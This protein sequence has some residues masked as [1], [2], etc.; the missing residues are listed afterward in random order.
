MRTF[1]G[2]RLVFRKKLIDNSTKFFWF[3][4]FDREYREK[5][6][7]KK[8]KKSVIKKNA[9]LFLFEIDKFSFFCTTNVHKQR[10]I[11]STIRDF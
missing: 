1:K 2:R 3:V 6:K 4:A 11:R 7:K 8:W 9:S 5:K 10:I